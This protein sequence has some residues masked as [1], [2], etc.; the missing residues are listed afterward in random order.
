LH[1]F[2]VIL[3]YIILNDPK[4]LKNLSER[5]VVRKE[6]LIRFGSFLNDAKDF[7]LK[8]EKSFLNDAKDFN[9]KSEKEINNCYK[10]CTVANI[11]LTLA[12]EEEKT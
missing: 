9:L 12:P 10:L 3:H 8:S 2:C 7:N 5:R 4:P 11:T 1:D 6:L